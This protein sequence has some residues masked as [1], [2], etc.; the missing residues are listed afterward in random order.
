MNVL[1]LCAGGASRRET[2]AQLFIN[3]LTVK[4][5]VSHIYEKLGIRDRATTTAVPQA[6]QLRT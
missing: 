2:A 5:R 4:T 1:R 3:V 6:R